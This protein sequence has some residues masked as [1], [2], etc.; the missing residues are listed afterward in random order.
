MVDF[1]RIWD[2]ADPMGSERRMREILQSTEEVHER[3]ELLTQIARAQ[4]MQG[5]VPE[6]HDLLCS[7]EEILPREK[8]RAHIRIELERGRLHNMSKSRKEAKQHFTQALTVADALGDDE[9]AV[10]A[11]H[12]IA[13]AEKPEKAIQWNQRAIERASASNSPRARRWLGSLHNNL[14]WTKFEMGLPEEALHHFQRALAY[15]EEK[16]H[17]RQI[18]IARWAIARV[19]RELGRHDEALEIQLDL[20]QYGPED[21]FVYEE[22]AHL[23]AIRGQQEQAT[24]YAQLALRLL[25]SDHWVASSQPERLN[26]IRCLL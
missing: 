4:G 20:A 17:I 26:A 14:G 8:T 23:L 13:I 11:M 12:M 3:A 25:E 10:D 18:Q 24:R 16:R 6:A 22:L 2:F 19:L 7:A 9:L 21:A 1:D 15:R 5:N